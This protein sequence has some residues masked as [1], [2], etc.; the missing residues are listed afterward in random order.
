MW[1]WVNGQLTGVKMTAAFSR[2]SNTPAVDSAVP[3]RDALPA[4]PPGLL[5]PTVRGQLPVRPHDPPP[6]ETQAV[7]QDV[8]D[9][10]GRSRIT[11]SPGD[12]TVT[13]DLPAP[14]V[15]DDRPHGL[16][17]GSLLWHPR[18]SRYPVAQILRYAPVP[19]GLSV[20]L[21][22][23]A[24]DPDATAVGAFVPLARRYVRI[25]SNQ[26]L[27]GLG[28]LRELREVLADLYAIGPRLPD[29]APYDDQLRPFETLPEDRWGQVFN[30]LARRLPTELYWSALLPL[31]YETVGDRGVRDLSEDLSDMYMTLENGFQLQRAGGTPGELLRWWGSWETNW[32]GTAVRTL[33]V[34][35]EVIVDLDM[36]IYG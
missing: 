25:V 12:L 11:R 23:L 8:S 32:G 18:R 6:G 35:H 29:H 5:L 24:G 10:P 21:M 15:A 4:Q 28:L 16:D 26:H 20:P 7:G 36:K 9:R 17:E 22:T 3:H 14:H 19:G 34:L 33:G 2:F 31:T 1:L 30:D 27:D 13:D